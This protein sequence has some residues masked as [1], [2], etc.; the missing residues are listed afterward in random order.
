M[1]ARPSAP[2]ARGEFQINE[3]RRFQEKTWLAQRVGWTIFVAL[4]I[5][6]SL[7]AFGSGLLGRTTA[8][9]PAD[10]FWVEYEPVARLTGPTE[11]TVHVDSRRVS[12]RQVHLVLGGDYPDAA[13]IQ[14]LLPWPAGG[15]ARPDGVVLTFDAHDGAGELKFVLHLKFN[16]IG[17][18]DGRLGMPGGPTLTITH[19]IHP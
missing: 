10:G 5:A 17:A 7:G 12:G 3:D 2:R 4:L 11:V 15:G 14:S 1:G 8:G 13:E 9:T 18:V 16:R 19:W 6:A